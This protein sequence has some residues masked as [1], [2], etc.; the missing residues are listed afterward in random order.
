LV[1]WL[2]DGELTNTSSTVILSGVR[3]TYLNINEDDTYLNVDSASWTVG[4]LSSAIIVSCLPCLRPVL[5]KA[6]PSLQVTREKN[7]GPTIQTIG[8]GYIARESTQSGGSRK[9]RNKFNFSNNRS[10]KSGLSSFSYGRDSSTDD[11]A[12]VEME[13]MSPSY[14][15]GTGTPLHH[16]ATH[17]PIPEHSEPD[18]PIQIPDSP[19]IKPP[20]SALIPPDKRD[21][22]LGLKSATYSVAVASAQS[23]NQSLTRDQGIQIQRDVT[24]NR[25]P[26]SS[27]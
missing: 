16:M 23:S 19:S 20:P 14:Q 12:R 5:Y 25:H 22:V 13:M 17:E 9:K 26:A 8:G 18:L 4:E 24:Q 2:E 27:S 6:F 10:T 21:E 11:L 7:T 15:N 1:V 3:I